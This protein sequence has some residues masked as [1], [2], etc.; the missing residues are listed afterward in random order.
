LTSTN[1][2]APRL[3][4]LNSLTGLRWFAA[5]AVFTYHSWQVC[6]VP[7]LQVVA[8]FGD[9]GVAFFF[10]LSGFVLAWSFSEKTRVTVFYWRRFA[11][12]WPALAVSTVFAFFALHQV[13]SVAAKDAFLCLT[14]LQAWHPNTLLTGNPV[15]W[16]L[17]AEAFFY[18]VFP[19]VIRPI[20][21]SKPYALVV[22]G[23]VLVGLD[24]GFRWWAF[25]EYLPHHDDV[26]H[27]LVVLRVPPYRL[28]EFLLGIVVASAMKQGWRPRIPLS[29]ALLLVAA[30]V[31]G[32]WW[33][34]RE[35]W[36]GQ[37]WWNQMLTPAFAV[38]IVAAAGADL[39]GRRSVFRARPLVV[40]GD[41][42]YAFYLIH[43]S[44]IRWL[45]P[46][47]HVAPGAHWQNLLALW[48]WA[49]VALVLSWLCYRFVEH[50]VNRFL[51]AVGPKNRPEPTVPAQLRPDGQSPEPEA[52][53]AGR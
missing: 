39:A 30:D 27:L 42:S 29:A 47:T 1:P 23:V 5:L 3:P 14:L 2:V 44:V 17:S 12:I 43:L 31:A 32:I 26:F 24:L 8:I 52:A 19:F 21:R 46:Y 50:P 20:L 48:T 53:L 36:L 16:S 40:L 4:R 33:C 38:L 41:W 37:Y 25:N 11:R 35:G 28:L 13:W 34:M 18:L 15:S 49:S 22:Y 9:A 51:C 10:V 6:R 7:K 45:L